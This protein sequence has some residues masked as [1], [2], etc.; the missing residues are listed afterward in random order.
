MR[1]FAALYP[2]DAAAAHLDLA[3][4][5]VRAHEQ[6]RPGGAPLVRWVPRE[7]WHVTVS[8]FGEVPDGAVPD[9][10]AALA[11]AAA[12]TPPLVL[13]LRGAG[14]FDRRVLWVGVGGDSDGLR[15]L[16]AGAAAAA[17]DVGVHGDRRPR[18]RAHVTVARA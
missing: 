14:V 1:L 3:L 7:Q 17:E 18:R 15:A 16:S 9:L 8:F 11:E 2:D 12:L 10:T 5:G 6:V 13:A 4:G